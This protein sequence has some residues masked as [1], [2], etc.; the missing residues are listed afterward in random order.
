M[1]HTHEEVTHGHAPHEPV[2]AHGGYGVLV[3]IAAILA[4]IV[5]GIAVLWAAPWDDDPATNDVVPGPD[6]TDDSGGGAPA[7]DDGG[8]GGEGQ[9][10]Q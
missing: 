9:P 6:I 3:A 5:L 2:D 7:P 1:A 4:I 10:A 8:S